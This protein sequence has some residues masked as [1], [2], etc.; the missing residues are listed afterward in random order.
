MW[1]ELTVV[2]LCALAAVPTQA[3]RSSGANPELS[4]DTIVPMRT[5]SLFSP[6][7]DSSLQNKYWDFGGDTIID[8]NRYV[9]L[10]QDR[11]GERGWLWTRTPIEANDFE[12]TA[13]FSVKGERRMN[14]GDGFA[15]WLTSTRAKD[16]PVFGNQDYF[17]GLGIMFDTYPNTPHRSV[18]PRISAVFNSGDM[19]YD[20]AHDGEG[21]DIAMC[22][23]QLRKT[24]VE[25]RLRFTYVRD[26][27]MELAIQNRK[28]NDWTVCFRIPPVDLDKPYLGFSAST[29]SVSDS[30]NIVSVW[31]NSLVYHSRS[32][33]DLERERQHIFGDTAKTQTNNWWNT[34]TSD[35]SWNSKEQSQADLRRPSVLH[36]LFSAIYRLIKWTLIIAMLLAAGYFGYQYYTKR[37]RRHTRRTL[38]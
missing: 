37:T 27:Y 29:G 2:V 4:A 38:A 28:W 36:R 9:R 18:F 25:T 35:S 10:T 23:E 34:G 12:I 6:F 14:S 31:T 24:D 3:V 7:V 13:E 30:H 11:T 8:T 33:A 5:H 32:A 22:S 15:L 17:K 19:S 20:M 1:W 16:G 21:Q 26:V